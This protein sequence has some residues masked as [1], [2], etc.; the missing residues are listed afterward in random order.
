MALATAFIWYLPGLRHQDART[1]TGAAGYVIDQGT[2][3]G[4][5]LVQEQAG[6]SSVRYEL[7]D[8]GTGQVTRS[9]VNVIAA[10]PAEIAWVGGCTARCRVHVLDVPG[11]MPKRSRCLREARPT[12]ARSAR[13]GGSLRSSCPPGS[14]RLATRLRT[15]LWPRLSRAGG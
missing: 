1:G 7:W 2:R 8:P 15:G 6:S 13:T 12:M 10:S 14:Q 9:F 4:L 5:L 3:A 11:G